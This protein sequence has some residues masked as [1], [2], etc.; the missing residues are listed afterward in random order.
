MELSMTIALV[1]A[2]AI[3]EVFTA[4]LITGFVL[5]A[6]DLEHLTVSRGRRALTDLM[7][8]LPRRVSVRREGQLVEIGLDELPSAIRY[9]SGRAVD[10]RRRSRRGRRVVSGSSHN[11]RRVGAR[12]RAA[13]TSGV[14][15]QYEPV[16]RDQHR[17]GANGARYDVR[18]NRRGGQR[19]DRQR[20]PIQ[21]IPDRL[22]GY[23]MYRAM[24]AAVVTFLVTH[25][26]RATI[27]VIIVA[28]A[29][30]VAAGKPLAMVEAIGRAARF[31]C[32][33]KGGIRLEALWSIDPV[34]LDKTAPSRPAT[35]ASRGSLPRRCVDSQGDRGG[36]YRRGA[37]GT[38]R[39]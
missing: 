15:G 20:A 9:L 14:R 23:L 24:A 13:W 11:H 36:H 4:L 7:Q 39:W 33:I 1:A 16:R 26:L 8:F 19:A 22:A 34:V 30:G 21:K 2:L 32:V 31:G 6:E 5:A 37:I 10:S 25:D 35:C 27:A 17:M 12:R 29:C 3:G 28:G 18:P 38:S